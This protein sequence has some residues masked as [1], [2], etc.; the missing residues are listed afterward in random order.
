[1]EAPFRTVVNVSRDAAVATRADL[2][3]DPVGV[4]SVN[5]MPGHWLQEQ[6]CLVCQAMEA[7][8]ETGWVYDFWGKGA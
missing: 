8:Q 7:V 5:C 4:V 6:G 3:H 1:M 2:I